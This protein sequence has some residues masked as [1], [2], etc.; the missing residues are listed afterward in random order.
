MIER[1]EINLLPAEYRIRKRGAVLPRS[2]IYPAVAFAVLAVVAGMIT[3][4][5]KDVESQLTSKIA[6]INREIEANKGLHGELREL[7]E[8]KKVTE[9]KIAALKQISV[10]R[11]R[12]VRLMEMLSAALPSYSW[13]VSVKE[14]A[15]SEGQPER[16]VIEARTYSFP[17]VAHY[18]SRLEM[19]DLVEQVYLTSVDQIQGQHRT[20]YRFELS[21]A[22][23]TG[24]KSE[25]VEQEAAEE[26]TT[27][28]G[29][30][31]R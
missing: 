24:A 9:G 3:L 1:I 21:C 4:Y 31:G 25:S 12:W 5:M 22:L 23:V 28:R 29:R 6:E 8:T 18:M 14:A 13:L 15:A 11:E 26:T 20:M 30:R 16:L 10:D 17:E 19:H 2:I 27:R 7:S